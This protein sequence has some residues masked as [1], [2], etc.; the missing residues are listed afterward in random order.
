MQKPQTH[1]KHVLHFDDTAL[2]D[3]GT[4]WRDLDG[5]AVPGL[6][7]SRSHHI[8]T[9]GG[10]NGLL[11]LHGA[12]CDE[13][14]CLGDVSLGHHRSGGGVVKFSE[15]RNHFT[16]GGITMRQHSRTF[17]PV[18]FPNSRNMHKV[19]ALTWCVAFAVNL[20]S[21]RHLSKVVVPDTS[22]L[23]FGSSLR[24]LQVSTIFTTCFLQGRP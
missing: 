4:D 19:I 3:G 14:L 12:P 17:F 24:C 5:A 21:D 7:A 10:Y 18:S 23:L 8:S 13:G 9:Q 11:L 1:L 6:P 16:C 15:D 2:K 20:C 22:H